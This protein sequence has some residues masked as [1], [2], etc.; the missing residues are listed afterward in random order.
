MHRS[1]PP[2][3]RCLQPCLVQLLHYRTHTQHVK[4]RHPNIQEPSSFANCTDHTVPLHPGKRWRHV[5]TESLAVWLR[6]WLRRWIPLRCAVYGR[7]PIIH[8]ASN[9]KL[10]DARSTDYPALVLDDLV[11]LSMGHQSDR[12]KA[13]EA[14]ISHGRPVIEKPRLHCAWNLPAA[15]V[16][17]LAPAAIFV[18]GLQ[19]KRS[20]F[21]V[22]SS[23]G[24]HAAG[25]FV[26][27]RRMRSS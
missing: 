4:F 26:L 24:G 5:A 10:P 17:G 15:L 23:T 2:S 12:D 18:A 9:E 13:T 25:A 20:A 3:L 7:Q 27:L 21:L 16:R 14:Y 19:D 8:Q 11:W 22:S 6:G 1:V